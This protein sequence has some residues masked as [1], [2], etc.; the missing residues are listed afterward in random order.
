MFRHMNNWHWTIVLGSFLAVVTLVIVQQS[1]LAE[2]QDPTGDPGTADTTNLV[3]NPLTEDLELSG[4]KLLD[5]ALE[6]DGS[7]TNNDVIAVD[8]GDIRI[9]NGRL[10]LDSCESTWPTGGSDP[11]HWDLYDNGSG[12][13]DGIWFDKEVGIGGNP[14]ENYQLT[15]EGSTGGLLKLRHGKIWNITGDLKF[16]AS[17]DVM[18]GTDQGADLGIRVAPG[19]PLHI[20]DNDNTSIFNI[21]NV[22]DDLWTGNRLARDGNERW[23][24]GMGDA[25]HG[26]GDDL[27]IRS[28]DNADVMTMTSAGNVGVGTTTPSADLDIIKMKSSGDT[29]DLRLWNTGSSNSR[30]VF[31]EYS[32]SPNFRIT[33]N[34]D[35]PH[36]NDGFSNWLEF[37]GRTDSQENG[38][39]IMTLQRDYY[40][41]KDTYHGVGIGIDHETNIDAK[42]RV[43]NYAGEDVMQLYDNGTEFFSAVDG[44]RIG[45]GVTDPD[46]AL[47]VANRPGD[48]YAAKFEGG[49]TVKADGENYLQLDY[50][51]TA[52]SGTCNSGTKGRMLFQYSSTHEGKLWICN[53]TGWEYI[54]SFQP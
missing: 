17:G 42:L 5:T 38:R 10:C 24:V 21:D 23:F 41:D 36:I 15:L 40:S 11:G 16:E 37:W 33:H 18:F 22:G 48:T 50:T 20:Q 52:P 51:S 47:H 46:Y 6:V 28:N 44:G 19:Y 9:T 1:A 53:Y 34:G 3:V 32:S 7:G 13:D 8:G 35:N 31:Q 29:V 4:K 39:P 45:M 27:I 2:W 14:H 26:K 12:F 54:Q 43:Q 25:G 30:I 49:L